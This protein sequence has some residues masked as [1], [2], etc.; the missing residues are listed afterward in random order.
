MVTYIFYYKNFS[1]I[2]SCR[3]EIK[4]EIAWKEKKKY[5]TNWVP[6]PLLEDVNCDLENDGV[7]VI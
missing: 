2:L 4:K 5:I 3:Y 6:K 7:P 1:Q